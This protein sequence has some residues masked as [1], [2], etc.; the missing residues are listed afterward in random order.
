MGIT[1]RQFIA[2]S[3]ITAGGALGFGLFG[4]PLVRR[5][6][7]ATTNRY[8][9]ILFL[10][11]GNDGLNTIT[12]ITNGGGQ[13]R[14]HY[15]TARNAGQGGLR[16]S[17]GELLALGTSGIVGTDPGTGADLGMH[18]G[19]AGFIPDR[20]EQSGDPGFGGLYALYQQ[21]KVA[22]IQGCGYPDYNLSHEESRTIW[23]TANPQYLGSISGR[24]WMGRHLEGAGFTGADIP[25]VNI[26]G[27]IAGE[28]RQF[29]TSVIAARR[30]QDFQFPIDDPFG[31]DEEEQA[32]RDV[33]E[34]LYGLASGGAQPQKTIGDTGSATYVSTQLFPQ[35][36]SAYSADRDPFSDGYRD[37]DRS[38]ARDFREIAKVIYAQEKASPISGIQARFFQLE[39]GGY[40]THSD[41]QAGQTTGQHYA[42]H[43]EVG[44]SLKHFFDDLQDM[45]GDPLVNRV[46]VVVWSEFSRRIEQNDNGTDHG[47]QGPMLVIGGNVNGGIYGRH[48]NIAPADLNDDGNT[49]YR[50]QAGHAFRSTD[51]RDVYGTVLTKW[52]GMGNGAAQ[53]VL[54][55]DGAPP[56]QQ[57]LYWTVSN[58]DLRRGADNAPLFK[59]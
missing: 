25:A 54:P 47:S 29:T 1:R 23:E 56:G 27:S 52:L 32:K 30:L 3:G 19:F 11:G 24:G 48:P 22:V 17:P 39:N 18:P 45:G 6:M 13:L 10:D 9:I 16:L 59:P 53:L 41:Q 26:G 7:A 51:F 8:T 4:H 34:A 49:V 5:A 33:F 36:H 44:A 43:A 2:R 28:L 31:E 15:E 37:I 40:D 50:Q 57:D 35:A 55:L 21:G 38:L 12:P 20:V 42:L 46:T 14:T 58:F